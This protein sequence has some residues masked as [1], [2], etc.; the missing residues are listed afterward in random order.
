M[1][2]VFIFLQDVLTTVTLLGCV[3]INSECLIVALVQYVKLSINLT[4]VQHLHIHV[5]FN[6]TIQ[7][8]LNSID[9]VM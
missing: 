3:L 5:W 8:G 4:V 1:F 9:T 2:N 7:V 6:T